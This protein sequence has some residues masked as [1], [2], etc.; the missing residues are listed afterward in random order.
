MADPVVALAEDSEEAVV[1]EDLAASAAVDL[2]AEAASVE[3]APAAAG[4]V[5]PAQFQGLDVAPACPDEGRGPSARHL[6]RKLER[7]R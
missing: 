6:R 7:Q 1:E 5:A 2:E 4:N 3:A